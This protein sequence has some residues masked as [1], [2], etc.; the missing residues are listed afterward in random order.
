MDMSEA[1][2]SNVA[3]PEPLGIKIPEPFP[4]VG[5]SITGAAAIL[6]PEAP[7]PEPAGA[8]AEELFLD[9]QASEGGQATTVKREA[10]KSGSLAADAEESPVIL[11]GDEP[12][13]AA[14]LELQIP[15]LEPVRAGGDLLPL[16]V[17]EEVASPAATG[18][19]SVRRAKVPEPE[20]LPSSPEEWPLE[21]EADDVLALSPL[22]TE[23]LEPELVVLPSEELPSLPTVDEQSHVFGPEPETDARDRWLW[24]DPERE[25]GYNSESFDLAGFLQRATQRFRDKPWTGGQSPG[26]LMA[27]PDQV[28]N[29]LEQIAGTL[30][31]EVLSDP[32]VTR[33]TYRLGLPA[34]GEG[35]D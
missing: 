25:S 27:H 2:E 19:A 15:E 26:R 35:D 9:T 8:E 31:L 14:A 4:D 20:P 3:D 24:V 18:L 30:G 11:A 5:K 12:S 29:G 22:E 34:S 21:L 32:K 33:G 17:G 13:L 6:E 7:K 28:A 1:L 16:D 23:V 10:P